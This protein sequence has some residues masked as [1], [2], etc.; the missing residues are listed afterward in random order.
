MDD[1]SRPP[2]A[3]ETSTESL[4]DRDPSAGAAYS[5]PPNHFP[6]RTSSLKNWEDFRAYMASSGA[7]LENA[8]G[9]TILSAEDVNDGADEQDGAKGVIDASS[10]SFLN[11]GAPRTDTEYSLFATPSGGSFASLPNTQADDFPRNNRADAPTTSHEPTGPKAATLEPP[12]APKDDSRM[13]VRVTL[14]DPDNRIIEVDLPRASTV[15]T[16]RSLV[17]PELVLLPYDLTA[18][19]IEHMGALVD[20]DVVVGDLEGVKH[21]GVKLV[22]PGAEVV[23]LEVGMKDRDVVG[24]EEEG[25][26]RT[27]RTAGEV[28]VRQSSGVF[29]EPFK[30]PNPKRHSSLY[31]HPCKTCG[32]LMTTCVSCSKPLCA[33]CAF[34]SQSRDL[35]TTSVV[36]VVNQPGVDGG[37]LEA[38]LEEDAGSRIVQCKGCRSMKQERDTVAVMRKRRTN[39]LVGT[40][41]LFVIALFFV[42]VA[43]GVLEIEHLCRMP[44]VFMKSHYIN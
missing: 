38:G 8:L 27:P 1:A 6:R 9:S 32:L 28:V 37:S 17:Y 24:D 39:V 26:M 31:S 42:L 23:D 5:P 36:T 21:G 30:G 43:V 41:I 34:L 29:W 22:V 11:V 18:T 12:P 15:S 20:E 40:S 33:N 19:R 25:G 13:V 35:P 44:M 10:P 2:P 14:P 3:V 16:L 4:V 7:A